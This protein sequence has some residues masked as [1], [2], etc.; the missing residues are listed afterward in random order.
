MLYRTSPFAN[1]ATDLRLPTEE[2]QVSS[3]M[4]DERAR[5]QEGDSPSSHDQQPEHTPSKRRKTEGHLFSQGNVKEPG[6]DIGNQEPENNLR[7]G[8][9]SSM[10]GL[11]AL[12]EAAVAA[13][14]VQTTSAGVPAEMEREIE[15]D[16]VERAHFLFRCDIQSCQSFIDTLQ[17]CVNLYK[18]DGMGERAAILASELG[19]FIDRMN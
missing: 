9:D 10:T 6:I 14:H 8:D 11:H 19:H 12:A 16:A 2:R 13:G 7:G 3:G 1:S 5:E 18:R 17:A 15:S 4:S